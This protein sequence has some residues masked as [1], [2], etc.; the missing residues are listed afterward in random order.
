MEESAPHQDL[1]L[2]RGWPQVPSVASPPSSFL[3]S[4]L[5]A[6]F[7][8]AHQSGTSSRRA[9]ALPSPTPWFAARTGVSCTQALTYAWTIYVVVRRPRRRGKV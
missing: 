3:P 5:S 2:D 9:A 1:F 4:L 7:E 8:A 6:V